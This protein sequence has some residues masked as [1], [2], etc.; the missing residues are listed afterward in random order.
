MWWCWGIQPRWPETG[1]GYIEFPKG[2]HPGKT[3][4]LAVT[5]FREKPDAKTAK[6]FV[7]RGNFFWNA[8]NVFLARR[9][10]ARNDAAVSAEDS[11][12]AG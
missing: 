2:T 9:D 10:S 11:H 6:R 8:G 1:Y 7:E 4:A 3:D 5:S 12:T